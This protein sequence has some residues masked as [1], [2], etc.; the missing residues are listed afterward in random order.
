[1]QEAA[2]GMLSDFRH[3][4]EKENMAVLL[5]NPAI[6]AMLTVIDREYAS[7]TFYAQLIDRNFLVTQ[8]T[9]PRLYRLF[10]IA[11]EKLAIDE[12]VFLYLNNEY[13][14]AAKTVG[15]E[16]DY[17]VILNS[18]CLEEYTDEELSA[19]LGHE[20]GHIGCG[21][22]A[23]LELIELLDDIAGLMP[24]RVAGA[25]LAAI[26]AAMLNWLGTADYTADRAAAICCGDAEI[27]LSALSKAVAGKE[28]RHGIN[29]DYRL[30]VKNAQGK[31][32]LDSVGMI[33]QLVA[34]TLIT[35]APVPF[36]TARMAELCKWCESEEC[37]ELFPQVYYN[38]AGN[39]RKR[40]RSG[41]FA[42]GTQSVA[43][44]HHLAKNGSPAAMD[45]L[46]RL[47]I[48]GKL[49]GRDIY[50]GV[51]YLRK[52]ALT[53]YENAIADLGLLL[54]RGIA[55]YVPR[56]TDTADWLLRY[57][58]GEETGFAARMR[59]R[60]LKAIRAGL[61][62]YT[63]KE[64]LRHIVI[65]EDYAAGNQGCKNDELRR[66]L[67]IPQNEVIYAYGQSADDSGEQVLAV[68]DTGIFFRKDGGFPRHISWGRFAEGK[69]AGRRSYYRIELVLDDV[70]LYSAAAKGLSAS[71]AG[72]LI[73][74][75]KTM[76]VGL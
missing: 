54:R 23:Y 68:C 20:L 69:V 62:Q 71:M 36:V 35:A 59:E 30:I 40:D 61:D 57:A 65:S 10:C 39:L 74:L 15:G 22:V 50:T 12:T 43:E 3:I 2:G 16:D 46:G 33:P 60:Y 44:M 38:F 66:N 52:A 29:Y 53:G 32:F 24:T 70:V 18:S 67:W 27:V 7:L 17:A 56:D 13:V 34:Q 1:M 11:K 31:A 9:Y 5:E 63:R 28:N 25:A 47:Y 41:S 64:Q 55:G 73:V 58:A 51:E 21:H 4:D 19:V 75:K 6:R 72:L 76:E 42:D 37:R 14:M 49:L 48:E 8:E 45:C 26:K